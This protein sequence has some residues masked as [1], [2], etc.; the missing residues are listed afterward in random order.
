MKKSWTVEELIVAVKN[1][2]SLRQVLIKLRL[3]EA[4]GNYSQIKK[5][6]KDLEIDNSHLKG[7]A[8]NKGLELNFKPRVSLEKILIKNSY[9]QSYKLK[10]RL[11]KEGLKRARCEECGWAKNS[12]DGRIP[13][14]LDH[15]NGDIRDNRLKNLRILCP[16]CHSLKET[17][18]GCNKKRGRVAE[19]YTHNT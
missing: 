7:Q 4:G 9:F 11:I 3:K 12:K 5:Y 19:W 2:T 17:H 18:R 13:V 1:S 15:I 16:N 14:E 6:I 10:K 8:W